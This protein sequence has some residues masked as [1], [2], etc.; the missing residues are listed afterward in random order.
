M[1]NALSANL[2]LLNSGE[3]FHGA[4]KLTRTMLAAGWRYMASSNG[5][6]SGTTNAS[7]TG[8]AATVSAFASNVQTL[9]GLANLT[10]GVVGQYITI[11]N[12]ATGGNNGTFLVVSFVSSSSVTVYNTTGTSSDANSG[13]IHWTLIRMASLDLWNVAGAVNLSNVSGGGSGSGTGVN[14][15][16]A[17]AS[18]GLSTITGVT[19]FSQNLSPGRFLKITGS[20][21]STTSGDTIYSNSG[22]FRIVSATAA[23]TSVTVYA[24]HLIAE[25]SN[26]ALA[27]VEQYGGNDGSITTFTSTTS[28]QST[29]IN[30]T[31][32]TFTGFTA[33][34]VGRRITI[35]NPSSVSNI[36]TFVIASFVSSSNVLLYSPGATASDANNP[37]LQWVETDPLQSFY[38]SYLQAANGQGAWL[39]LGGPTTLKIPIGSNSPT[40]TFIRGENLTQTATGAQGELLGIITDTAGGTGYLVVAPRVVGTGSSGFTGGLYGWNNSTTD[41]VTGAVSAATVTSTAGPPIAYIR[42]MVFWKNNAATGHIYYQC[43]DQSSST[44]SATTPLTGRFSTM[45]NTLSQVTAQV[46]PGGAS[47][48]TPATNGFPTTGTLCMNG[49][50]GAGSASTG[51]SSSY[52]SGANATSPGR[53]HQI[54]AS[55]VEQQGISQDGS[56][57]NLQSGGSSGYMG[58][59]LHRM[60]NQEDGDL[61]PYVCQTQASYTLATISRTVANSGLS[62]TDL[63]NTGSSWVTS[64]VNWRGFRRR[65]LSSETFIGMAIAFLCD[66]VAAGAFILHQNPGYPDQIATTPTITYLREPI[67]IYSGAQNYAAVLGPNRMRKGTPRWVMLTQGVSC[68]QTMDSL[69]WICLSSV[70]SSAQFVVGPWDGVTTPTF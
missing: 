51:V 36:G 17:S 20:T 65:G 46:C 60:D 1:A 69:K 56:W 68:N 45:A 70:N 7:Q 26:S 35:L 66:P 12:A 61:D 29:L 3:F 57:I 21:T 53:A 4:W 5:Q 59:G 19:S 38:P 27:V 55:N 14:I 2:V 6:S 48:G 39:V 67:W 15:G 25:T 24:P 42:E 47:S 13:T 9:T 32:S 49:T 18:T 54:V 28:G 63:F 44:E 30:F 52:W 62:G 33:A 23:G 34:D 8:T 22:S 37:N 31:T 11:S 43:I 58:L 16:A 10:A 64:N 50:G 40:G 41:T